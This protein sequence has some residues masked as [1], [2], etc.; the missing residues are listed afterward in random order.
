MKK[1]LARAGVLM[2]KNIHRNR[3]LPKLLAATAFV[4]NFVWKDYLGTSVALVTSAFGLFIF[5]ERLNVPTLRT[6]TAL[7]EKHFHSINGILFFLIGATLT[8]LLFP[9]FINSEDFL[10]SFVCAATFVLVLLLVIKVWDDTVLKKHKLLVKGSVDLRAKI[11][12]DRVTNSI[13]LLCLFVSIDGADLMY[14]LNLL[15]SFSH[16]MA[17]VTKSIKSVILRM[18]HSI[19]KERKSKTETETFAHARK[20]IDDRL[21]TR[22]FHSRTLSRGVPLLTFSFV[23]CLPFVVI[24]YQI[25]LLKLNFVLLLTMIALSAPGLVAILL[26]EPPWRIGKGRG[27][28]SRNKILAFSFLPPILVSIAVSFFSFPN[29]SLP[30]PALF[31]TLITGVVGLPLLRGLINMEQ[32]DYEGAIMWIKTLGF[33][34][35]SLLLFVDVYAQWISQGFQGFSQASFVFLTCIVL[36]ICSIFFRMVVHILYVQFIEGYKE[37]EKRDVDKWINVIFVPGLNIETFASTIGF[38]SLLGIFCLIGFAFFG[39]AC[40]LLNALMSLA[41]GFVVGEMLQ[42]R[43]D[44]GMRGALS[45]ALFEIL[46]C[47]VSN[48]IYF[49]SLFPTSLNSLNSFFH[50][51]P[52]LSFLLLTSAFW[53]IPIGTILASPAGRD[54]IINKLFHAK[55]VRSS[56]NGSADVH[57][58]G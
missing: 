15:V 35:F 8:K 22:P 46:G 40:I 49:L 44:R 20:D 38:G 33:G 21:W 41:F 23:A 27:I 12:Y 1:L 47:T 42:K 45:I 43:S 4:M 32:L 57:Q 25:D 50:A 37:A 5:L 48:A 10:V 3:N 16:E 36:F 58:A 54:K 56:Q 53:T 14:L 19:W 52:T 29:L 26:V 9:F 11:D 6:E 18:A 17:L 24:S 30:I 7:R 55:Q 39:W 13:C 31:F 34:I 2:K 51:L 28:K